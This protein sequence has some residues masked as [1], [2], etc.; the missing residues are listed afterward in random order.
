M[1]RGILR[2][3]LFLG[4]LL[5]LVQAYAQPV[6]NFTVT[7]DHGCSPL[8]VSFK[9]TSTGRIASYFWD[10][11]NGNTSVQKNPGAI[12]TTGGSYDVKLVVKDSSGQTDTIIKTG[13]VVVSS[14]PKVGFTIDKAAG[15]TPLTVNFTDTSSATGGINSWQWDFGDGSISS[16]RNPSHTYATSGTYTV[17]L[18]VTDANGCKNT[19]VR[20]KIITA[21]STPTVF[22]SADLTDFCDSIA[23]VRFNDNTTNEVAG[24]VRWHWDF[25][26]GDTS[27]Q[28]RPQHTYKHFGSYSV[29]LVV[30][31]QG[32]C[33]DSFTRTGYINLVKH[34]YD[35]KADTTHGCGLFEINFTNLTSPN[36]F[37]L[38]YRW[39]F[40]DGN[41][42][43]LVNPSNIYENPGHYTV[44]LYV[45]SP[46]GCSDTV[47]KTNY[48]N[49]GTQ[50]TA[51]FTSSD[52]ISCKPPMTVKF[53]DQSTNAA[54]WLWRFGDG[55]TSTLKNPS[56]TYNAYGKFT[57]TLVV[58]N[59]EGCPDSTVF[60]D[61]AQ[62]TKPVPTIYSPE[63]FGC[64]DNNTIL[65][66]DHTESVVPVKKWYWDFGDG[67]TS[68]QQNPFHSYA[69]TGKYTVKLKIETDS[70]CVDSVSIPK[71]VLIGNKPRALF[72][73]TPQDSCIQD[74]LVTFINK[75]DSFTPNPDKYIW[76]Y[77][78]GETFTTSSPIG[79]KKFYNVN[80]GKYTV[81][82]IVFSNGCSDTMTRPDYITIHGPKANFDFYQSPCRPDSIYF[83]DRS[84][85][86]NQY[87]WHFG[88]GDSS[89]SRNPAHFYPVAGT[90]RV[91]L[92]VWD[93]VMGCYNDTFRIVSVP[94][95]RKYA[96]GFS[97]NQTSGCFPV[98][99]SF[100]DT[101]FSAVSWSWDFG[102]GQTSQQSSAVVTYDEPGLY[103][104][105]ETITNSFGCTETVTRTNYITVYG[106]T[107][108][109]DICTAQECG[110]GGVRFFDFTR[111]SDPIQK[112]VWDFGDGSTLTTTDTVVTHTYTSLPS[113]QY[114]GYTVR[115]T[116]TDSANCSGSQTAKVRLTHPQFDI[117]YSTEPDCNGLEYFFF[118]FP[119]NGTPVGPIDYRWSLQNGPF[120]ATGSG[121]DVLFDTSGKY[122]IRVAYTDYY[123]CTDTTT[124]S[125]TV[126]VEKLKVGFTQSDTFSTCPPF[127]VQFTDTSVRGNAAITKWQWDF[128]DGTTSALKDPEKIYVL[129][130]QYNVSLTVT[131]AANCTKTVSKANIVH[132]KGPT[133]TYSFSP[134]KGCDSVVAVFHASSHNA[135]RLN[136]DLG[137][138]TI[139]NDSNFTHVYKTP[140]TYVPLLILGDTLGCTYKAPAYDTIHVWG[141]N[142]A[143]MSASDTAICDTG[144]VHFFDRTVYAQTPSYWFW[145]FGDGT[146][147]NDTNPTHF[148][149]HYDSF[150]VKLIIRD[151]TGCYDSITKKKWI[152]VS[153]QI[154][155][156]IGLGS[157]NQC[158]QQTVS[159]IDSTTSPLY[160]ITSWNWDFG[161]GNTS[162]SQNPTHSY[163]TSGS[164][165]VK[166][167]VTNAHGCTDSVSRTILLLH[168]PTAR[169]I[170][171][172]GCFGDTLTFTD[173]STSVDGTVSSRVIYFGDGDSSTSAVVKHYYNNYGTYSVKLVT[174][175]Q[176]GCI[177]SVRQT[178]IISPKPKANFA[179]APVCQYDSLRLID[180]TT[181]GAGSI[182]Q[183]AW[184]F[185][186]GD[187][188]GT[189]NPAHHYASPGRYDVTL[190]VTSDMGCVDSIKKT[191]TVHA[192]PQA[193]FQFLNICNADT[194]K[195]V[196][197]SSV[198][199]DTLT[200]W[201]WNFGDGNVSALQSPVHHYDTSGTYTVQLKV[202]SGHGCTD[203]TSQ[204]IT[205]YPMPKA[206][207]ATANVCFGNNVS[208]SD[209]SGIA[210][211]SIAGRTWDFG[212]STTS[213]QSSPQH[214]YGRSGNFTVK[215]VVVSDHGCTDSIS[216][217]VT[218]YPKPV[219]KFSATTVC[220]DDTTR[221]ADSSR[222]SSGSI[223]SWAWDL[224]DG[225]TSTDQN[226]KHAYAGN[227]TYTVSLKVTT[228]NGCTDSISSN[229]LVYPKP[230]ASFTPSNACLVDSAH[231]VNTS[232][233][234]SGSITKYKW[235]FGDGDTS[236]QTSPF[237]HYT[238]PGSYAVTL[239]VNSDQGCKD[240]V[241]DS[242]TIY[243][244]PKA[245]YSVPGVCLNDSSRF[246]NSSSV[247]T[248]NI[249]SYAWD[250]GDGNTSASVSPAHLYA[251]SGTYNVKLIVT[252][253]H[254]CTDT[255]SKQAM[256]Y[257]KPAASFTFANACLVDTVLFNNTSTVSSGSIIGSLWDFGDGSSSTLGSPKH[258]FN[259]AGTYTVTLIATTDKGCTDTIKQDIIIYPKPK[260]NFSNTT[261]CFRNATGFT[262]QSNV[263]SGSIASYLWYFGDGQTST[264][265]NPVYLYL[266]SG[267]YTVKEIVTSDH[268]CRDSITQTITV[269]PKPIAG[270]TAGNVCYGNAA[271]FVDASTVSSG[272]VIA[273]DWDFGDGSAS[274]SL[275]NPQHYYQAGTYHPVLVVTTDHGCKDTFTATIVINPKPV[276]DFTHTDVCLSDST[277]FV[278]KSTVS[279][280]SIESY[281]WDF[282][283][284]QI[285]TKQ[286]PWHKY[287][288]SGTYNVTLYVASDSGCKD[289]VTIPITIFPMPKAAFGVQPTCKLQP[290]PFIDS[291]AVSSGNVVAWQWNFGDGRTSTLQNPTHIYTK[292]TT[293]SVRLIS[294]T[295]HGCVD[296]TYRKQVIYPLPKTDFHF[297]INCVYDPVQ[298]TDISTIK[299]G[300][301]VRWHWDFADGDTSSDQD[302]T[303]LYA[304]DGMYNVMLVTTSSYG[305]MDTVKHDVIVNPK[306][307]TNWY[308][309]PV[310]L[311]DST[312]F[313]D[314]TTIHNPGH[315]K[316]WYWEFG[317]GDTSHR[318]NPVHLYN[319]ADSFFVKMVTVSDSGCADTLIK[320]A[321]V[322]PLPKASWRSGNVCLNDTTRFF[323]RSTIKTGIVN[324]W[325]WKFGD[326]NTATVQNAKHMYG[327]PGTYTVT[328][329]A[330]SSH[331]CV[332]SFTNKVTVY[333]RTV[334][335]FHVDGVC[336]NEPS[337]FYDSTTIIG[338]KVQSWQWDFGDG[339]TM[340]LP[341][342]L[343]LYR[344]P[345]IYKV[346]LVTTS[347]NG[348]SDTF[349][350]NAQVYNLPVANFKPQSLC[351]PDSI[352]FQD[353]STS[354]DGKVVSRQWDFG[355]GSKSS[356]SMPKHKYR[357]VGYYNV[358]LK[359]ITNLGCQDFIKKTI[360]VV[361]LYPDFA[362]SDTLGC[363]NK[364]I[365]FTDK[366]KSDTLLSSWLWDFGDGITGNTQNPI[367]SYSE[368][369]FY[370]V[371]LKITDATGC[372]TIITKHRLIQIL[373]TTAPVAPKIYRVTVQ[374]DNSVRI[375]F[376]KYNGIDFSNYVLER[377]M[378]GGNFQSVYTSSKRTDTVY[379]E[380]G[381]QTLHNTYTYRLI[382]NN[383]C[384]YLTPSFRTVSHTTINATARIALNKAPVVWT[385]YK[386][387]P[388]KYYVIYRQD[389]NHTGKWDS[390]A[391]VQD[392]NYIDT[393]IICYR[394][395]QYRI[396]AVGLDSIR[397]IS[398]SDTAAVTPMYV[399]NVRPNDII[400]ATVQDDNETVLVE[401][402]PSVNRKPWYYILERSKD[403]INYSQVGVF[404]RGHYSGVDYNVDVHDTSYYYRMTVQDSCGDLSSLSNIGKTILLKA[405]DTLSID[406]PG[407]V[408]T[409]YHEWPLGV[410]YYVVQL[411]NKTTGEW[412]TV[413]T[414]GAVD[415]QFV[416]QV[417]NINVPEYCYRV[418]GY[419]RHNNSIVS[420][421]NQVCMQTQ[422]K[423]YVPNAFT[424]TND[425]RNESFSA[426][427]I[428][429][430]QYD[431]KIYDRWGE[432]LFE[433][434]DINKGWDGYFQGRKC[435]QDVYIYEIFAKG[436]GGQTFSKKGNV[437]LLR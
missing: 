414:V 61:L 357:K 214:N 143:D 128:G 366:S 360:H 353:I 161:D 255:V 310:C 14:L 301:I 88:D 369:G 105:K 413:G 433:T 397:Q 383:I 119:S 179:A 158:Q 235:D 386:G 365:T 331:N 312:R 112:R 67:D 294:T 3:L 427:G 374:D 249:I 326:G 348:C 57:V 155:P 273:W 111:S 170:T 99:V 45:S 211:G 241:T 229:V 186:D 36:P 77:G 145:D 114:D 118:A 335:N 406:H 221:F 152:I 325:L 306:P 333:P 101:T 133:G 110:A 281:W 109:F 308:A 46:S 58:K 56:H 372:D 85:G 25:G 234:S 332:D 189:E 426:K 429:V 47:V 27:S 66:F 287:G 411:R 282:G 139:V 203:S 117:S 254:G 295:D 34:T 417:T 213:S 24:K 244:R 347:D 175:S 233:V 87:L 279:K 418:V 243:P 311:H 196:D 409:H 230:V 72:Y 140:G 10:F 289:T 339:T 220:L 393:A 352:V 1:G 425:G 84:L 125:V 180:S 149:T 329:F 355:D 17:S 309:A 89:T 63:P 151:S 392:T 307:N 208:F 134:A 185:G 240:T 430:F 364:A 345:G 376:A 356:D 212:D 60:K 146:T 261:E 39:D 70:G 399:P 38:N 391:T 436:S 302:P 106:V 264:Q 423:V 33:K 129:P 90:Y 257:P 260:A 400:R 156:Q 388:V 324:H 195:F 422:M 421:S 396:K 225:T 142:H 419:Q 78:N 169:L 198:T 137:D 435:Q 288:S 193:G 385:P 342:P 362:V 43:T 370:D 35:F 251:S 268:G 120:T 48:I 285:S 210:S 246:T 20:S 98:S 188:S 182:L 253:D 51:A 337:R 390:L 296:T 201:T 204:Q 192:K 284:G 286:S 402:D 19:V 404:P 150:T 55:T 424:P 218:V 258:L 358:S 94:D 171:S 5:C 104:V 389:V 28:Q 199:N 319:R 160:P 127:T 50:P 274:S 367:H 18:I 93:T 224:G 9:N 395:H 166:L 205:V 420:V 266:A 83:T 172:N 30:T 163:D 239:Y 7:N 381:L 100:A 304:A 349:Y 278:D 317:D 318:Q 387:W 121:Y 371:S 298:F 207:F 354:K 91:T 276:A 252:T 81:K 343:H 6:A 92:K 174:I 116:V 401:W 269:Y 378:G 159:F 351:L 415:T 410:D 290:A 407:L 275:Q 361:N 375:E 177:D 219:A 53:T 42:S 184:N 245:D 305:C 23:T 270:F 359:V 283:D 271:Q 292:D 122:R 147:S 328:L 73:A 108:S 247:S 190:K 29:K 130:G 373:D 65:F 178:V 232:L 398:W 380:T 277:H 437:T 227:A 79:P 148:Y 71:Y 217:S 197:Q 340:S 315:V 135:S 2:V 4:T 8:I 323:D 259:T 228:D 223:I 96:A 59:A 293:Y 64:K 97:A 194:A 215:L 21:A 209:S 13:A 336:Q 168:K 346:R 202:T 76:D 341:N 321:V 226:P 403:N 49:I 68:M 102:N 187:T 408:W 238:A 15:C 322:W 31:N 431:M 154:K 40:G 297:T 74:M 37:G 115:L 80:P 382:I 300:N 280:G 432:L 167:T 173:S 200:A 132:V 428:F 248:G 136:W 22:L 165:T 316:S 379:T 338:G 54:S 265:Q 86:D 52:S 262:D 299:S 62:I 138:G 368:S 44:K 12:Y 131:D 176:F 237:H 272:S 434:N 394:T 263:S 157:P 103:T 126:D 69:D 412:N 267:T 314:S 256:V 313:I 250:F 231:F 291:S 181:I 330:Y 124:D 242:V 153:D 334:P 11:G 107:P 350:R 191:V 75:S 384:G 162:A 222:L 32:V 113:N 216:K 95:F 236:I 327:A 141:H 164:F 303:H 144:I 377:D 344:N 183:W 82:L 405:D 16:S 26:D 123:G 363:L 320:R 206:D 41:S 416:D